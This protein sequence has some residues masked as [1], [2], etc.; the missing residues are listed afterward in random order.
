MADLVTIEAETR[1]GTGKGVARAVRHASRLPGVI[2]GP[3]APALAVSVEPRAILR[4]ISQPG[5]RSRI[6][7]L[8][9]GGDTVRTLIRDVQFHPVTDLPLHV[10]FQRLTAGRKVRVA[11]GVLFTN[12]GTSPGVKR[13]GVLNVVR[14]TVEVYC[15]P[16]Q[17]PERFEADLGG[18]DINDTVRWS[19][20]TGTAN[21]RPVIGSRNFVVATI[22]PPTKMA[23]VVTETTTATAAAAPTAA[24]GEA[25][26]TPGATVAAKAAPGKGAGT[27][28]GNK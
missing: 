25:A 28:S 8:Q 10:D 5:W 18:L 12:E 19:D 13:G 20:L 24:G 4:E 26:A 16:D 7:A 27:K 2:Y 22:A 3:G 17:V 1:T 15:D 23:E 11:V 21:T 9:V 14:H 6:F